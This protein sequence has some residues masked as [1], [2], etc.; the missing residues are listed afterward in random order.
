V[1]WMGNV[2]LGKGIQYLVQAARLLLGRSIQ[3][4]VAGVI[5]ISP[6]IVRSF[7]PNMRI[8][9]RV[10][11]DRLNE[12][13][14]QAHAFVLPTISDGF[15]VTQLEAMAHGLPVV[16]TPNCGRVVTDG[17]D[18]LIVPARDGQALADALARLDGNR[19][20]LREMSR[21]ALE[22]IRKYDLPS[23]ARLICKLTAESRMQLNSTAPTL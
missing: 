23:N 19:P 13:Y 1:L 21:N 5:W 16:I 2:V 4:L 14:R 20:L 12:T 8:L 3:I 11:R 22:T 7:P 18:G 10:T 6:E 9:G 15:A 17:F